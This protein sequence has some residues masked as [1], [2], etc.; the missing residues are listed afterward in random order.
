[1]TQRRNSLRSLRP[2]FTPNP[3]RQSHVLSKQLEPDP[4]A[5]DLEIE[6]KKASMLQV[7]REQQ[8]ESARRLYEIAKEQS[9]EVSE[10]DEKSVQAS[11]AW[12]AQSLGLQ[13]FSF[14]QVLFSSRW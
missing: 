4:T 9:T 2:T 6:K 3:I 10:P 11:L 1:M 14:A 8:L 7:L 5:A 13:Q 12:S